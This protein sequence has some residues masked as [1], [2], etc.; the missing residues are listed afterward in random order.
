MPRISDLP[1]VF[2]WTLFILA[3]TGIGAWPVQAH[4]AEKT[5]PGQTFVVSGT[6]VADDKT[7][8][9]GV[10]VMIAEA[11]DA[12]Y[13]L[14]LGEGGSL[15]NPRAVTDARGRFAITVTR[16]LFKNRQ[17]F[18][19]V[20][21][22][23]TAQ[24]RP[25]AGARPQHRP[26]DCRHPSG[27]CLGPAPGKRH[28]QRG[29]GHP[30]VE[31]DAEADVLA[32]TGGQH[33]G[34][35]HAQ[36]SGRKVEAPARGLPRPAL[37][38]CPLQRTLWRRQPDGARLLVIRLLALGPRERHRDQRGEHAGRGKKGDPSETHE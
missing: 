33:L 5:H 37:L 27:Q 12:G 19:V 14:S 18:V 32:G 38:A 30:P 15:L 9:N 6:L 4:R 2:T 3:I 21:P 1:I 31:S 10:R 29:A 24:P 17:E 34:G 20:V 7:P 22:S 25:A 28:V 8:L 11:K 26:A 36:V 16:S 23:G 35:T 13:T